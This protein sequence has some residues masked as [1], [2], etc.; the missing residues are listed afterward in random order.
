LDAIENIASGLDTS[1]TPLDPKVFVDALLD[2]HKKFSDLVTVA[3]RGE[4]GFVAALD[5]AFREF[6]NRNKISKNST[7]KS[8]ELLAKYCDS[9]LKKSAKN[10]EEGELEDLLN[11][12]MIIF[13]YVEDKDVFQKFYSRMLARRLVG[14]NSASDDAEASMISKLKEACGYEYTSKL[15]RMFTDMG[16]SKDLNDQFRNQQETNHDSSDLIDFNIMVLSTA[17]WPLTPAT[18]PFNLPHDLIPTYERFQKFYQAKHS[19]RKLNWCFNHSKGELKATYAKASKAGYTF[20]VST[21]QMGILLPFND[22]LSYTIEELTN[23]TELQ[24]EILHGSLAVLLKAKVLTISPDG[25]ECGEPGTKYTLNLEFKSRKIRVNLN[26]QI[27]S[28]QKIETEETH[29]NVEED[30]KILMQAAIVRIMKTRKMMKYQQLITEVI[31][32]LQNRFKPSVP[33]IKKSID[34]LLEK[35]YIARGEAEKD[36]I[37]YVA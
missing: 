35:E 26:V 7:N 31:G 33:D 3:F 22:A 21:F 27:K 34:M 8:P 30:R 10:P 25:S 12:I 29:K 16:V 9:L 2:V 6:V 15:Q 37:T 36:T 14:Q 19:G 28:E 4:S 18:T 20:Q 5:K 11:N 32:Q 23:I 24:P 1:D 13:K 17:S